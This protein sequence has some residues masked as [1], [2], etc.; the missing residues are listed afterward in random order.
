MRLS[1]NSI[2]LK[3]KMDRVAAAE[4]SQAKRE[5]EKYADKE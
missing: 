1:G 2:A 3:E 4:K 5:G